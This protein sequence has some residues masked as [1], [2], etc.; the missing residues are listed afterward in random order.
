VFYC[1][2]SLAS[3][4][5]DNTELEPTEITDFRE[6]IF[7]IFRVEPRLCVEFLNT[8]KSFENIS[9]IEKANIYSNFILKLQGFKL[10]KLTKN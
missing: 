3:L 2:K 7:Q 4:F 5:D 6:C 9:H 1:N 10:I 8:I